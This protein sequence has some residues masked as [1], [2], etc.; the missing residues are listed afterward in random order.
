MQMKKRHKPSRDVAFASAA[1]PT[2][3]DDFWIFRQPLELPEEIGRLEDLPLW[4]PQLAAKYLKKCFE[5]SYL[6]NTVLLVLHAVVSPDLFGLDLHSPLLLPTRNA[7]LTDQLVRRFVYVS[8]ANQL[9]RASFHQRIVRE[10]YGK[11]GAALLFIS[12]NSRPD[13]KPPC[14][15]LLQLAYKAEWPP[16]LW[17]DL[18]SVALPQDTNGTP[19]KGWFE[20]ATQ[21]YSSNW[22]QVVGRDFAF[23]PKV[24]HRVSHPIDCDLSEKSEFKVKV[25]QALAE[26]HDY[27]RRVGC[28]LPLGNVLLV[29]PRPVH[30]LGRRRTLQ[31]QLGFS[32]LTLV[33][34]PDAEITVELIRRCHLVADRLNSLLNTAVSVGARS[35]GAGAEDAFQMITH[36]FGN[37][38]SYVPAEAP[39]ATRVLLVEDQVV[40]AA[41][42]LF[43]HGKPQKDDSLEFS[44][45]WVTWMADACCKQGQELNFDPGPLPGS[46]IESRLF[47]LLLELGRNCVK[48]SS[49][50]PKHGTMMVSRQ[51]GSDHCRITTNNS[52]D[53]RCPRDLLEK[54]RMMDGKR[55]RTEGLDFILWLTWSLAGRNASVVFKV[56]E[57]EQD[58]PAE[59]LERISARFEE[60][61]VEFCVARRVLD[62]MSNL[63]RTESSRNFYVRCEIKNVPLVTKL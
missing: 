5:A 13:L 62:E 55:L 26:D 52:C 31:K 32:G 15:H 36:S 19:D 48:H 57:F 6:P 39:Q 53:Y 45:R 3:P 30:V 49:A 28:L 2:A 20:F 40:R 21:R 33:L 43:T 61:P 23:H 41:R 10:F 44:E 50:N 47:A 17:A 4:A 38:V 58:D 11:H 63:E 42:L 59:A 14:V 9:H 29:S 22:D 24:T 34:S 7:G 54:A 60:M 16:H 25:E 8:L 56:S 18:D 12:G 1:Q 51:A 37:A 35:R 27:L 46:R